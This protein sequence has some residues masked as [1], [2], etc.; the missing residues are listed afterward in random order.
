[1]RGACFISATPTK[2]FGIS[3]VSVRTGNSELEALT[4]LLRH[5]RGW[6]WGAALVLLLLSL[7]A[8]ARVRH[9]DGWARDNFTRAERMREALNGRPVEQRSRHDYQSVIDAYRR[10]YF[11]APASSKA[12]ASVVAVAELQVEMGRRF[13][14]P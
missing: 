11:G 1:M 4:T 10:V 5:Q 3:Q 14:D 9:G 7:P 8:L 12:D 2:G 13:D 6:H